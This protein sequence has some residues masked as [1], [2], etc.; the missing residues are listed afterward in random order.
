MLQFRE[1][2]LNLEDRE[3]KTLCRSRPAY[4]NKLTVSDSGPELQNTIVG[5]IGRKGAGKSTFTQELLSYCERLFLFNTMGEHLWIPDQF[6]DLAQAHTYIFDHGH[7]PGSFHGAFI[8]EGTA[9]DSTERDFAEISIAVYE[10]GNMTFVVEE[11]P[12]LTQPN[13]VPPAFNRNVRLG[14]HRCLNVVYTG[15]RIAECPRRVTAATDVFVLF[16][17]TEPDDIAK[18]SERCSP[19]VADMVA[20]LEPHEF[21]V[22]DTKAREIVVVDN[23]WYSTLLN[24]KEN[25]TPAYGGKHGRPALWSLDDGA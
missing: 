12:M 16:S 10:A 19:E 6:T 24:S 23:V 3:E 13:Y 17:Q 1:M 11:L 25:W 18:I 21:V 14:R 4:V 2:P 22:Y 9:Q 8:P 7:A 15:Q 20:A 5:I